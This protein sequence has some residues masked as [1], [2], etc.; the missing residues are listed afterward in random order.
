[1]LKNLIRNYYKLLDEKLENW[2]VVVV[3][4]AFLI[5]SVS[6]LTKDTNVATQLNK[7]MTILDKY[8]I[9]ADLNP[10]Y[11]PLNYGFKN[12]MLAIIKINFITFILNCFIYNL[13]VLDCLVLLK[14]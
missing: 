9:I 3:L 12:N 14:L 8:F 11:S 10:V 4:I 13:L 2:T 6:L 7:I 5:I 1:M